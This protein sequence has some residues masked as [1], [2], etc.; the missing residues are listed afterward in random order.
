[1]YIHTPLEAIPLFYPN[2][3]STISTISNYVHTSKY[4]V[5]GITPSPTAFACFVSKAVLASPDLFALYQYV[6][7]VTVQ[8]QG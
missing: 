4:H 8:T 6:S 7:G 3:F 2:C 5:C 1:M